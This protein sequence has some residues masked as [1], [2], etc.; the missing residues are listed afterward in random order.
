MSCIPISPA[1]RT[2]LETLR[3]WPAVDVDKLRQTPE[4]RDAL[5]W[6]WVME[7]GE[8]TGSGLRHVGGQPDGILAT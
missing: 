6:G 7:S 2:L 8:L 4:W 3:A 1:M 5:A